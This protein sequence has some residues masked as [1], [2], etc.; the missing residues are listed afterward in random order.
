MYC[1]SV[2]SPAA[3]CS[4]GLIA[5]HRSQIGWNADR[6]TGSDRPSAEGS[7]IVAISAPLPRWESTCAMVQSVQ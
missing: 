7:I 5:F 4:S 6:S 1:A 3:A 2:I